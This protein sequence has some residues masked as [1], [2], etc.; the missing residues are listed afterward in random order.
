MLD[1]SEYQKR[2]TDRKLYE[3]RDIIVFEDGAYRLKNLPT[4]RTINAIRNNLTSEEDVEF[5][6]D[7]NYL[8]SI[9]EKEAA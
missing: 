8:R 7:L 2:V 3:L 5:M 1:T 6:K 4:E 9:L